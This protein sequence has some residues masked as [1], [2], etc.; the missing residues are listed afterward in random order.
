M[1]LSYAVW[2]SGLFLF[3]FFCSLV[4]EVGGS[5]AFW[6]VRSSSDQ[7]DRINIRALARDNTFCV[8]GQDTSLSEYFSPPRCKNGNRRT[9][10]SFLFR[11]EFKIHLVALYYKNRNMLWPNGPLCSY[12][13]FTFTSEVT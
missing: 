13:D 8:L 10:P 1:F 4:K 11:K 12:A 3:S 5:V 7:A 2:L 6:L 9:Y